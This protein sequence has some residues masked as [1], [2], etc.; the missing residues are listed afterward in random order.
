MNTIISIL[1]YPLPRTKAIEFRYNK[2]MKR[3]ILSESEADA[4]LSMRQKEDYFMGKFRF[5]IPESSF[6]TL[7]AKL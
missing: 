2:E 5:K 4:L 1:D 6:K 7:I 3:V